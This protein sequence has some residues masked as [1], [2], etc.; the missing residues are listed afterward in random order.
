MSTR[1]VCERVREK[2]NA[3]LRND[4][5]TPAGASER[6]LCVERERSGYMHHCSEH[7]K[8]SERASALGRRSFAFARHT[9]SGAIARRDR[10][11]WCVYVSYERERVCVCAVCI[12]LSVR[13]LSC[14]VGIVG[15]GA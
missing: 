1:T 2:S 4:A 6:A 8:A 14:R 12:T 5:V 15:G 13:S 3:L 10:E 9:E 7:G 11:T